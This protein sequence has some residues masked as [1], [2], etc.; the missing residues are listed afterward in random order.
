MTMQDVQEIRL[1]AD[2]VL[3][4]PDWFTPEQVSTACGAEL[5]EVSS[6]NPYARE[7]A[8]HLDGEPFSSIVFRCP[9][10]PEA[11]SSSLAIMYVARDV[12][13]TRT[14]MAARFELPI[15]SARINPR[16]PPD[17]T[18]SFTLGQGARTIRLRFDARSKLLRDVSVHENR[19][20]FRRPSSGSLE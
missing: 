16:I 3:A 4:A 14:D 15:E 7:F 8:A 11:R 10:A 2:N 13:I 18:V 9:L 6:T 5:R 17:G 12:R 1:I 19:A 20:Q